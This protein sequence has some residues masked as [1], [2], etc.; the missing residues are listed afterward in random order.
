[1]IQKCKER[2]IVFLKL[3]FLTGHKSCACATA[4]LR[5]PS[6]SGAHCL[7]IYWSNYKCMFLFF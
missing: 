2:I 5:C 3:S 6:L 4:G 7:K 1:M